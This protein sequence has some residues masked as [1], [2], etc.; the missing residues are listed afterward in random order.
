MSLIS[1]VSTVP[2]GTWI[3]N[4]AN[5]YTLSHYECVSLI[6]IQFPRSPRFPFEYSF[7]IATVSFSHYYVDELIANTLFH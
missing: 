3:D 4:D 2:L 1:I 5:G 6:K 7:S